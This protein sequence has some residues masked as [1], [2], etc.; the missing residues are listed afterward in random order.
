MGKARQAH[1]GSVHCQV[2]YAPHSGGLVSIPRTGRSGECRRAEYIDIFVRGIGISVH[3][4][5]TRL[6]Q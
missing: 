6:Y 1:D 3:I 4:H 2:S 5:G